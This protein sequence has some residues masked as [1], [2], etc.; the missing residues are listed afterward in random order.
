[1]FL[2]QR[3]H[4]TIVH[5]SERG[6]KFTECQSDEIRYVFLPGMGETDR[7]AVFARG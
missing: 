4:Y 5:F 6:D 3:K 2:E 7:E 1:M